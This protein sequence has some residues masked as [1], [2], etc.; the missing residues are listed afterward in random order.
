MA[1]SGEPDSSQSYAEKG[2]LAVTRQARNLRVMGPKSGLSLENR[3]EN[4]TQLS[5]VSSQA[6]LYTPIRCEPISSRAITQ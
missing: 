2:M 3:E 4:G 1:V 6:Y 5:T